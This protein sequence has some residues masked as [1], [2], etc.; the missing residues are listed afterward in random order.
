[1]NLVPVSGAT[2]TSKKVEFEKVTLG[3][4]RDNF[5]TSVVTLGGN[6]E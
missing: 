1:M 3:N 6:Y 5:T 4:D 2:S